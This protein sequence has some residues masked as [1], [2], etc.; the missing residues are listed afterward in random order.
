MQPA[1]FLPPDALAPYIAFYGIIDVADDFKEPYVSPPLALCGFIISLEGIV[2]ARLKGELFMKGRY[3]ATGQVTAPV[4][5]E[6][7]GK[8][9]T[10]MVFIHPCGLHQLFGVNMSLLTNN[11]MPLSELLGNEA[12]DKLIEKLETATSNEALIEAMNNFFLAQPVIEIN[13]KVKAAID[14]IQKNKGNVTVNDIERNCFITLRSLQRYFKE[15]IGLSPQEYAKIFRFK[16]LMNYIKENPEVSWTKLCEENGYYDQAHL[17]R[18]FTKY[19]KIKP[20]EL[21]KL[22]LDFINYLL[23]N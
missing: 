3:C 15:Y 9:K 20:N 17:T 4:I 8:S 1:H 18:Y 16:C 7:A 23:Q 5:G 13:T 14:Y 2:D 11:S 19:M 12:C 22:E 21:V 6:T 10:L